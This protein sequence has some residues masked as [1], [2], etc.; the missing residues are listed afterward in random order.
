MSHMRNVNIIA[1]LISLSVQPV[2]AQSSLA[3]FPEN[4]EARLLSSELIASYAAGRT[5]KE[6]LVIE[7]M[8]TDFAVFRQVK[9]QNGSVYLLFTN[10]E[11]GEYPLFSRGSYI[12]KSDRK[13]GALTQIKIFL[14]SETGSFIRI[15]ADGRRSLAEVYL[16]DYQLYRNLVIPIPLE[17]IALEPFG[18]IRELSRYQI[19]WDLLLPLHIDPADMT[20]RNM[21]ASIRDVLG[22]L[23]DSDDGAMDADGGFR[24]IE[25]L[26]DNLESGFNCSGFAK[27]IVDGVYYPRT[28]SLLSIEKLKEKHTE[29]RGNQWSLVFEEERDPYFGLDWT[30]NLACSVLYL[31]SQ[32]HISP[33]GADV[34][35]VK[36]FSYTEDVGFRMQDLRVIFYILAVRQPGFFYLGSV[37]RDFGSDPVLK[38]HTHVAVL[39]PYFD[40]NGIFKVSVFERNVETGISSLQRRYPSDHIHLVR[41]PVTNSFILPSVE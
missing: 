29:L 26:T 13:T 18:R 25:D 19:D 8:S 4:V 2:S 32:S 5:S 28:G 30:R 20:A 3:V 41:V 17:Q 38:Q 23:K 7:Q 21:V 10:E 34:R 11:G 35:Y 9:E 6:T 36:H 16:F 33:E 37:N 15:T 12:F 1:F 27:W 39:F 22:T 40:N 31:H 24:L 14:H